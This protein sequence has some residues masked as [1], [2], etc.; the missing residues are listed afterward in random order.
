VPYIAADFTGWRYKKM[1]PVHQMTKDL[2]NYHSK[3]FDFCKSIGKIKKHT[4]TLEECSKKERKEF[5][6][7][8]VR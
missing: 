1:V 4:D 5:E 3:L 6:A 7:M 2:D 8:R